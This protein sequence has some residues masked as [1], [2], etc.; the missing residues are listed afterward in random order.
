MDA[1][2]DL[3]ARREDRETRLAAIPISR[4]YSQERR[5]TIAVHVGRFRHNGV[6]T[7]HPKAEVRAGALDT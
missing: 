6:N 2:I 4:F 5:T 3:C 1:L 7:V